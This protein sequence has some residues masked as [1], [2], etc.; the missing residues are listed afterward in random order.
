MAAHGPGSAPHPG[1]PR[2]INM[3]F[4]SATA[5]AFV[6][7]CAPACKVPRIDDASLLTLVSVLLFA[8]PHLDSVGLL[9]ADRRSILAGVYLATGLMPH[10]LLEP[11]A[12]LRQSDTAAARLAGGSRAPVRRS[13]DR[14][15]G[16]NPS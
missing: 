9:G 16:G 15:A 14:P 13:R 10:N 6:P 4:L 1:S 8:L 3:V 12:Q 11:R 5:R 7:E 2:R